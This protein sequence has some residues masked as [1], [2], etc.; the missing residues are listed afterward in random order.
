MMKVPY[1][2]II[3]EKEVAANAVSVRK[4]GEGDLG[5]V[6][7]VDFVKKIK[8]EVDSVMQFDFKK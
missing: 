1:M 5:S 8:D 7:A 2:V 6:S 4:H 3:G